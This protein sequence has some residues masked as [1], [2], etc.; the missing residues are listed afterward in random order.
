MDYGYLQHVSES[1]YGGRSFRTEKV[2]V[3]NKFGSRW[4]ALYEGHWRKVYIQKEREKV[5]ILVKDVKIPIQIQG[6]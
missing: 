3:K 2:P 6:V 4:L 1:Q 5:F